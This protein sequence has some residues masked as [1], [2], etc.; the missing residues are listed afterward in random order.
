MSYNTDLHC[1]DG[2]V[3][4]GTWFRPSTPPVASVIVAPG[5]AAEARFY[6]PFCE[7]LAGCGLQT[8]TF[9]FR[10]V[11][12]STCDPERR[13]RASFSDWIER[14]F[15]AA[16]RQA[17]TAAPTLPLIVVGHSAGGWMAGVQPSTSLI[18][19]L[20]GIAAL[21]AHW[22]LIAKPHRYAH[23]LAW[24]LLVPVAC[25]TL[26]T[27]PGIIGF[28]KRLQP[29]FGLEFSRWARH[30]DFVFSEA[31]LGRNANRFRGHLHLFQIADDP[32][33]TEA[34]VEAFSHKFPHAASKQIERILPL[35][36]SGASIGHFG[37]FRRMYAE[38]LWPQIHAAIAD[39]VRSVSEERNTFAAENTAVMQAGVSL[40]SKT[41]EPLRHVDKRL[42]G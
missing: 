39:I 33:G 21:S 1:D 31:R 12:R 2:A 11:G 24:H 30:R 15:P 35:G 27:W 26:R 7:Y 3:L 5:A 16:I 20:V 28:R 34:A 41:N 42:A 13:R 37:M 40:Q 8:L 25:T 29:G 17:R 36:D 23:W 4:K 18:D 19:G 6:H 10:T 32:W 22:R 9:D 14:D 38:S